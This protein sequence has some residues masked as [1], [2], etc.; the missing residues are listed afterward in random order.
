MENASLEGRPVEPELRCPKCGGAM[1]KG[2]MTDHFNY[3]SKVQSEWVSGAPE[4]SFW[5][6][7]KITG[8]KRLKV[9]AYRCTGCGYLE[10]YAR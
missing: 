2:I 5:T 3:T 1:E 6:G 8:K 9:V 10:S 7:V 4:L